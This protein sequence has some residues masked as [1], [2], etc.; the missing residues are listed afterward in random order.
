MSRERTIHPDP[1]VMKV[2]EVMRSIEPRPMPTERRRSQYGFEQ[3]Q[4]PVCL[5]WCSTRKGQYNMHWTNAHGTPFWRELELIK[6]L[7]K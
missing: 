2:R 6:L 5:E 3:E 7:A 4:C 1:L